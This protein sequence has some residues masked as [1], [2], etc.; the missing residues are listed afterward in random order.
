[1]TLPF[2]IS[3]VRYIG[4]ALFS[5]LSACRNNNIRLRLCLQSSLPDGLAV[6]NDLMKVQAI[7]QNKDVRRF[8]CF[9][10]QNI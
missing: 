4:P 5:Y 2:S 1:M 9:F 7:T 10:G 3:Q 6:A 8:S